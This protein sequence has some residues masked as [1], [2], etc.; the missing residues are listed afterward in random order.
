MDER[1]DLFWLTVFH[2]WVG[3]ATGVLCGWSHLICSQ[4]AERDE[5]LMLCSLLFI[6]SE[7]PAH[8]MQLLTVKMV[9]LTSM[10]PTE[11][12]PHRD[13]HEVYLSGD[14]KS[15]KDTISITDIGWCTG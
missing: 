6:Q 14:H 10:N 5:T 3:M 9:C 8:G 12:L 13:V 2:G 11:T 1:E 4:E 7:T 15:Y